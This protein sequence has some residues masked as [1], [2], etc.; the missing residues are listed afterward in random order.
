MADQRVEALR[1]AVSD[2]TSSDGA[3]LD[4]ALHAASLYALAGDRVA[5]AEDSA[6][7]ALGFGSE[8]FVSLDKAMH[9]AETLEQSGKA[10]INFF[11]AAS[12]NPHADQHD[13]SRQASKQQWENFDFTYVLAQ[14]CRDGLNLMRHETDVPDAAV[15][16]HSQCT[17]AFSAELIATHYS[18]GAKL[19]DG[20]VVE[21]GNQNALAD[22]LNFADE[23]AKQTMTQAGEEVAIAAIR[24]YESARILRQGS[25]DEQLSAL[26]YYWQATLLSQVSIYL[27]SP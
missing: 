23:R 15:F 26:F 17:F 27:M 25:P 19:L 6:D 9:I 24:Y 10:N 5:F 1:I 18:L 22:M 8:P 4:I 7:I 12:V 13:I 20:E 16:G 11:E 14:A 3:I 21:I 2:E